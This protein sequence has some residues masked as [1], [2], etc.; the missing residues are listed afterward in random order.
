MSFD[1]ERLAQPSLRTLRAYDPGHD[2]PALRKRFAAVLAELGSNENPL[3]PSPQAMEAAQR[4]IGEMHRYPDPRAG[5]L[6]EALA[7]KFAVSAACLA[8]GNG[9]H[10][11]LMLLAQCFAG[12]HATVMRSQYGFAVFALATAAS[13]AKPLC[14]PALSADDRQAPLGH[15]LEAMADALHDGVRLVYL[16]NPNNPTGTWF[17]HD[18]LRAFLRRVPL[19][20]LVVVDEAYGEY[21]QAPDLA[22]AWTMH[23]EFPNLVVTRTFSKAYALAG[24]RAGYL[25]AH[26][27]VTSVLERLRES[28]NL[29]HVAMTAATAALSDTQHLDISMSRNAVARDALAG[30][31]A[32]RG[33]RTLPSQTNFLLMTL[34]TLA[35]PIEH[36]LIERGVVVRPMGGYGLPGTL[37]IS[38]GTADENQRLLEALA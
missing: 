10:E 25:L 34:E 29:N 21:M 35:D 13:G 17:S 32:R 38:I 36:H 19:D 12:P 3:G 8:F 9:S 16:A 7:E 15:D 23:A 18:S 1:A 30:E 27:S 28:F 11:L 20:T 26:P 5:M 6:R 14:V 4:A 31:L 37:R 2:L 22:S 33:Y 24:L